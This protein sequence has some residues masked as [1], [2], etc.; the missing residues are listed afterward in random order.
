MSEQ[1]KQDSQA[2]PERADTTTLLRD[3]VTLQVKLLVDGLRDAVLIPLSLLAALIS[4]L[5]PGP[6][7][8]RLFYEVVR[9]G[10]RSERWINLFAAADRV[11]SAEDPSEEEA[12]LDDYLAQVERRLSKEFREGEVK[13]SAGRSID[14]LIDRI[15]K[16]RSSFRKPDQEQK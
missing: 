10:R 11:Y 13:D 9:M 16:A 7:R 4:L 8:G 1:E 12:G 14:A 6:D 2:G 5:Q 3:A 15:R